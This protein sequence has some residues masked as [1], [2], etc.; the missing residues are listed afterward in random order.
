MVFFS[1]PATSEAKNEVTGAQE[2]NHEVLEDK[3]VSSNDDD[4]DVRKAEPAHA[5]SRA[6]TASAEV[7]RNFTRG[8]LAHSRRLTERGKQLFSGAVARAT[9]EQTAPRSEPPRLRIVLTG[10]P[11]RIKILAARQLSEWKIGNPG[12]T[13]DTR[14]RSAMIIAAACAVLALVGVSLATHFAA[15]FLASPALRS[16]STAGAGAGA[17]SKTVGPQAPAS[18]SPAAQHSG[19]GGAQSPENQKSA[20]TTAAANAQG[21]KSSQRPEG[22]RKHHR[23]A[24]DDYVAPNTY[25]YYGNSASH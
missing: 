17:G 10:L 22:R 18:A 13:Y 16:G 25:K 1:S 5:P 12:A 20:A 3:E 4:D 19:A 14:L 23:T 24:D 7:V 21:E 15:R 2:L 9:R 11:L 6:W 8:S